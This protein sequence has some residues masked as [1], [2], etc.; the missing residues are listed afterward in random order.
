MHP[1]RHSLPRTSGRRRKEMELVASNNRS[2]EGQSE[3]ARIMESIPAEQSLQGRCWFH[4]P[5][6]WIDGRVL[7][8]V[9]DCV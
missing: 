7:G 4:Q 2:A 5:G 8:E 3:E 9:E 6:V 1:S